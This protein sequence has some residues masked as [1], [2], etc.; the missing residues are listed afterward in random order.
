MLSSLPLRIIAIAGLIGELLF[1]VYAWIISPLLFGVTLEPAN[2]V[3]AL[4]KIYLGIA[5]PYPLAFAVHI[6]V[7]VLGFGLAVWCVHRFAKLPLVTAGVVGGFLLW[8]VAQGFLAHLVGRDFMIGFGSYTQ[9]SFFAHI[10]MATLMGLIMDRLSHA[11]SS[12]TQI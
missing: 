2:L 1:E 9:S 3:A 6:F 8:F 11:S 5:L 12:V 4:S 7:G 10:G